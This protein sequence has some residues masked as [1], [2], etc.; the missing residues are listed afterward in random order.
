MIP[1]LSVLL[2]PAA[3]PADSPAG[4]APATAGAT[5]AATPVV[6]RWAQPVHLATPYRWTWSAGVAPVTDGVLLELAVDPAWL[7]PTALA[8]P[9][10]YAGARPVERMNVGWP[11]GCLL[12]FAAAPFDL[13]TDP[14]YFGLPA[15]PERVDDWQGEQALATARAL[16]LEGRGADAVAILAPPLDLPD[17]EAAYRVAAE[18]VLACAPD[19]ADRARG[20]LLPVIGR[21][22]GASP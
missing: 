1:L 4:P 20:W 14:V 21:R 9:V 13:A 8:Q 17:A 6:V 11:S 5:P 15:L 2:L 12:A 7:V 19:E 10:L 18:R 22:P 3:L 16:G